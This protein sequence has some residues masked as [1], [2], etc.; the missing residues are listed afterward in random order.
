VEARNRGISILPL[1]INKSDVEFTSENNSIRIG[2]KAV[3]GMEKSFLDSIVSARKERAFTSLQDFVR[4]TSVNKNVTENLILGGA[5]DW[6]SANR[7]CMLW[8]C[9]SCITASKGACS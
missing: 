5:F 6:F 2:L 9:P 1:D 4:R 7:R 8:I 3:K